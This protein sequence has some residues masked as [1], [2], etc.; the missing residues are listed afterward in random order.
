MWRDQY[1]GGASTTNLQGL[2]VQLP[3]AAERGVVPQ[4][5]RA[6]APKLAHPV[7]TMLVLPVAKLFDRGA[8]FAPSTLVHPRVPAPFVAIN[9]VDAERIGIADGDDVE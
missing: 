5:A 4:A 2:G 6:E 1:Y 7:G 9:P 8:T 3:S